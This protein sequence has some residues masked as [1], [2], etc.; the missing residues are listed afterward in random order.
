MSKKYVIQVLL[1]TTPAERAAA[2]LAGIFEKMEQSFGKSAA[3]AAKAG[4]ASASA[5]DKTAAAAG[6]ANAAATAAASGFDRA[7]A[8]AT[9]FDLAVRSAA[10]S[11][12]QLGGT[13]MPAFTRQLANARTEALQLGSA[14]AKLQIGGPGGGAGGT[15]LGIF[16]AGGGGLPASL[17]T[18]RTFQQEPCPSGGP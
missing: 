1:D 4:A 14:M 9:G 16:G 7:K 10:A 13:V 3:S 5:F 6:R 2:R 11:Y 15:G 8:A 12:A 18:V 17:K